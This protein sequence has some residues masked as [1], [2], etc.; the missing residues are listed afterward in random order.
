MY[1]ALLLVM[2]FIPVYAHLG[3]I[4][5]TVYDQT[6]NQPL[7]GATVQLTGLGKAALTNELGQFRFDGLVEAPYKLEISHVG[8]QTQVIP[9]TVPDD[10]TTF[11]KVS[12]VNAPI[13]LQQVRVSGQRP[14]DQQLISSLDIKLRPIIN[15]QEILRLVPGLFIGQHA[16]GGRDAGQ[17]GVACARAGVC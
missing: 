10:Q 5:G 14:H 17:Y 4:A 7:R 3:N 16:G 13:E 2:G 12:L 1:T 9:V 6:T 15:S 11:V 8:F